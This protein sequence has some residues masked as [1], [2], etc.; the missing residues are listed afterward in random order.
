MDSTTSFSTY[1]VCDVSPVFSS[2]GCHPN[3]AVADMSFDQPIALVWKPLVDGAFLSHSPQKLILE[4]KVANIPFITG[5]CDDEGTLFA[6][7]SLN[8][9]WTCDFISVVVLTV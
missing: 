4:G 9:T 8:I 2:R 3:L 1:Q 6:F 5:S 7:A